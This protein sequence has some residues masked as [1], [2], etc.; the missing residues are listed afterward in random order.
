MGGDQ[1]PDG[2]HPVPAR[3]S[4][5]ST[6]TGSASRRPRRLRTTADDGRD[7]MSMFRDLVAQVLDDGYAEAAA[8]RQSDGRTKRG[9]GRLSL[10]FVALM[11]L[12]LLLTVAAVHAQR[13]EPAEEHERAELIDRIETGTDRLDAL[14]GQAQELHARVSGLQSEVLA[15]SGEGQAL[16]E[17]V[18]DLELLTGTARTAGPGI[19]ISVDDAPSDGVEEQGDAS[20]RVLDIDLQHVTNGL[21]WAGAEAV[22]INGQRLTTM[23][24]IR[25]AD[26]AITVDY[27][28]L[29]RPYVIEAIGDPSTLQAQFLESTGGTWMTNLAKNENI[30][31][32]MSESDELVLSGSSEAQLRHAQSGGSR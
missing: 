15:R 1:E 13:S 18:A 4:P 6:G 23:S 29:A 31:F 30:H 32:E 16:Q 8:R 19:T 20:G 14:Q 7:S 25:G 22:S 5:D 28:P 24:A 17:E 9:A 21:W 27:R 26:R 10:A 3:S 12:G 11:V 2:A